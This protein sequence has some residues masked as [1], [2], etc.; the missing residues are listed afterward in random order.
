MAKLQNGAVVAQYLY[1]ATGNQQYELNGSGTMQHQNV[2]AGGKLWATSE[3]GHVYYPYTDWLGTK[4]AQADE[5]GANVTTWASLP[6]GDGQYQTGSID[7]TEHHFTGKERDAESGLDDFGA[8]Y[9]ASGMG[10]WMSPD[11]SAKPEGVPYS[12]LA[13]PQSLD[14]YS[15]VDN[16]P[17]AHVDEDGH[18][19]LDYERRKA[20]RLAWEDERQLVQQ[21]G[22]GTVQWTA[23][24]K[25]ELLSRGRVTGYQ[26]HHI[27]SVN[28][29]PEM[30]GDPNNIK[31][32]E[33]NLAEHGGDFRNMTEGPLINRSSMLND[34][35]AGLMFLDAMVN[36]IG[37][38]RTE[39]I[40]GVNEGLTGELSI[41]DPGK[42]A[43]TLDGA[44][45]ETYS[46]WTG[47]STGTY[48]IHDGQFYDAD[49]NAVDPKRV[50]GKNFIILPR[51]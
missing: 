13:N 9:Y 42:A 45:I 17:L 25:A 44:G 50:K 28:G 27:N 33:D 39:A 23:E 32:T 38:A 43:T 18:A 24:E 36:A 41:G 46:W 1:D 48:S 20:V 51:S 22:R 29:H 37:Q 30:A 15:Y 11:W 49:G 2:V 26:G 4:R 40:T 12:S 3:N 8:R 47:K 10:R 16:N 31:F 21:R 5:A 34:V 14:L 35:S 6:F 19:S 7:A